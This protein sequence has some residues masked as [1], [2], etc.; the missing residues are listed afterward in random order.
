MERSHLIRSDLT[1]GQRT[2]RLPGIFMKSREGVNSFLLR[3]FET[4]KRILNRRER[5][6]DLDCA[7][8][9]TK[10]LYKEPTKTSTK[11]KNKSRTAKIGVNFKAIFE[12]SNFKNKIS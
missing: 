1:M 4:W 12:K 7:S 10:K 6:D 11:N 8:I 3:S 5:A 9:C 2:T